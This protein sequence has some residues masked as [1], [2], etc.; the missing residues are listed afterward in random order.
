M[1]PTS[2]KSRQ[3]ISRLLT[4]ARAKKIDPGLYNRLPGAFYAAALARF[5]SLALLASLSTISR[6][7]FAF[8]SHLPHKVSV[9]LESKKYWAP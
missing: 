4:P 3:L 2:V 8:P 1:F 7:S 5:D 6:T 9:G